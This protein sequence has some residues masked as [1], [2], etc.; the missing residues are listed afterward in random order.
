MND[1]HMSRFEAQRPLMFSIAYRMLGSASD[2]EDI[3]Q[4]A[5]LRYQSTAPEQIV[6]DKAFLSTIVTRLSLNQLQSARS[7]RETYIGTWL[8]EPV[9]TDTGDLAT[10]AHEA[11]LH[12]SISI[13][14]L[15][16]L[17]QL[18]PLERAVL[19]LRDVFDYDY[20]EIAAMLDREEA[21]CRQIFHRARQH[22]AAHKPRFTPDPAQHREMLTRFI[23]AVQV[24]EMDGL[25][26]MLSQ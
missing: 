14:F 18:T 25:L 1:A 21:A 15:T 4:E 3:L 19:L 8:P 13:A 9:L 12:E 22:I 23:D 10:P 7:Q 26:R 6:S 20:P 5:Y 2:A 16:L 24:G 17:E 11:E